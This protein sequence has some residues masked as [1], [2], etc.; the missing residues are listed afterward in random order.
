M[1]L[2]LEKRAQKKIVDRIIYIIKKFRYY[3][4]RVLF[5]SNLI[6]SFI[7]TE[8]NEK[9]SLIKKSMSKFENIVDTL[10]RKSFNSHLCS[11][12]SAG[13]INNNKLIS[14]GINRYKNNST[15]HA[16]VDAILKSGIKNLKGFDIIVI[17]F[18]CQLNN[19]RPCNNC[20]DFMLKKGIRKV[21]YSDKNGDIK[22]EYINDMEKIHVCSFYRK[23]YSIK[24]NR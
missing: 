6:S 21:Y 11:K 8:K 18:T 17:R 7:K 24:P 22:Q 10:I 1:E 15:I 9:I 2:F 5:L 23:T 14:I 20:I 13:I 4:F 19:S 3:I 16:E 12:H